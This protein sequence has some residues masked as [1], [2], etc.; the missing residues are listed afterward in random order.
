MNV[1]F[2]APLKSPRDPTPSGDR[3]IA[4]L[5]MAALERAGHSVDLASYLR[6]FEGHGDSNRQTELRLAAEAEVRRIVDGVVSGKLQRPDFW[7]TYHVYHKAPD[8][9]GPD[10][11]SSLGIPYAIIEAS[12]S[13]KQESGPW[14]DGHYAACRS[15]GAANLIMGLNPRDGD[16]VRPL[17]NAQAS[18][19]ELKPFIDV[20]V[21][22][23]ADARRARAQLS[24]V[25]GVDADNVWLL[26]VGMMR[27]GDKTHSYQAL[28]TSLSQI[29]EL[30]WHLFVVGDGP[31]SGSVHD[32]FAPFGSRVTWLGE[33]DPLSMPDIYAAMDVLTWPAVNE[34]L[35][36]IFL[37][38]GAAGVPAV[39]GYTDGVASLLPDGQS[40]I[41]VPANDPSAFA[42]AIDELIADRDRRHRL[43]QSAKRYVE[44][45][46]SIEAVAKTLDAALRNAAS[47]GGS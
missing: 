29:P 33:Q 41:V 9:I 7:V 5:T 32:L 35:G 31:N 24:K 17:M 43:G 23:H 12:I 3:Q 26:A 40:G 46:H 34:A 15:V 11:G 37:E 30:P 10:V 19:V 16:C 2:Y 36:M 39:A 20:D 45:H 44:G 13:P 42:R 27:S 25:H 21:F 28:A 47:R 38:A 22:R 4:R 6:T 1:A 8:W 18:Y 14:Q